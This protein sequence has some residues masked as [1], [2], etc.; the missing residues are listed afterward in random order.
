M[1]V[2]IVGISSLLITILGIGTLCAQDS[3]MIYRIR[4]ISVLGVLPSTAGISDEELERL[5]DIII[6]ALQ[7]TKRFTIHDMTSLVI[8]SDDKSMFVTEVLDGIRDTETGRVKTPTLLGKEVKK[9]DLEKM[10]DAYAVFIPALFGFQF[11]PFH[12]R[13][14]EV[15]GQRKI[16]R[17]LELDLKLIFSFVNMGR[18]QEVDI[19]P[20]TLHLH[21]MAFKEGEGILTPAEWAE[22]Q[23]GLATDVLSQIPQRLAYEISIHPYFNPHTQVSLIQGDIIEIEL[24]WGE[25]IRAGDE[26]FLHPMDQQEGL[27]QVSGKPTGLVRVMDVDDYTAKSRIIYGNPAK[28]YPAQPGVMRGI[29]LETF[30]GMMMW[31]RSAETNM[32][33]RG[34]DKPSYVNAFAGVGISLELGYMF[35]LQANVIQTFPIDKTSYFSTIGDVGL[36]A[37]IYRRLWE[38]DIGAMASMGFGYSKFTWKWLEGIMFARGNGFH[39]SSTL[40]YRLSPHIYIGGQLGFR[41]LFFHNYMFVT[42]DYYGEMNRVTKEAKTLLINELTK[43]TYDTIP[44]EKM[45]SPVLSFLFSARF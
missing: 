29:N 13:E 34:E 39:V 8:S 7:R 12:N 27:N 2:L 14:A 21:G 37:S 38:I 17:G 3:N 10:R 11:S 1:K 19:Y 31:K 22:L 44:K 18:Y 24:N 26:M 32:I 20:I 33:L 9:A 45:I 28:R 4:D 42:Y 6:Q 41:M 30:A 23:P 35:R 43:D 40:R 25:Q 5:N 15:G 16:I 36:Q